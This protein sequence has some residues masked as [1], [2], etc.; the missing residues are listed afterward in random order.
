MLRGQHICSHEARVFG[1]FFFNFFNAIETIIKIHTPTTND[2][3]AVF[4]DVKLS[5]N[6]TG[7]GLPCLRKT[8]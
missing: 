5:R 7:F 8:N 3:V 2:G 6:F 1:A 4:L